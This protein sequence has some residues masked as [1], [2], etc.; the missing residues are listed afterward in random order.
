[1]GPRND[2]CK[3]SMDNGGDMA[4]PGSGCCGRRSGSG[5]SGGGG[6]DCG[7]GGGEEGFD[8]EDDGEDNDIDIDIDKAKLGLGSGGSGRTLGFVFLFAASRERLFVLSAFANMGGMGGTGGAG[9]G[10]GRGDRG[11]G[12]CG[13]GMDADARMAAASAGACCSIAGGGGSG[14]TCRSCCCCCCCC[15]WGRRGAS[16]SSELNRKRGNTGSARLRLLPRRGRL[17]PPLPLPRL[18]P[19][20]ELEGRAPP[21]PPLRRPTK[22]GMLM[23]KRELWEGARELD[24]C[25]VADVRVDIGEIIT[26]PPSRTSGVEESGGAG[27]MGVVPV[28]A[29]TLMVMS[30]GGAFLLSMVSL[31]EEGWAARCCCSLAARLRRSHH[32]KVNVATM[33]IDKITGGMMAAASMEPRGL[34]GEVE[35]QIYI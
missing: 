5:G 9:G 35:R 29:S 33:P 1:V 19:L 16:M 13:G 32:M 23:R 18:A 30:G 25:G 17:P 15:C 4:C 34:W 10:G 21:P 7:W 6:G 14:G 26:R 3:D 8:D 24:W 20:P 12:D 11:G 2:G 22:P 27:V 31:G 28:L